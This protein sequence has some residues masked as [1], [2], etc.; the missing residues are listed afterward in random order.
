MATFFVGRLAALADQ[1][2]GAS[3]RRRKIAGRSEPAAYAT[4]GV[5]TSDRPSSPLDVDGVIS[6]FG[7]EGPSS[8]VPGRFHLI[9]GMAHC[10]PDGIGG[11]L[12]RLGRGLRAGLGDRLGGPRQRPPAG[13]PRAARRAPVPDL[14]RQR[15][16]RHGP[17]E[18]RRPSTATPGSA[19][20]LGGRLH[21]RDLPGLGGRARRPHPPGPDR[22]DIGPHRRAR[23]GPARAGSRRGVHCLTRGGVLADLLPGGDP[24][25]PRRRPALPRLVGDQADARDRGG[26]PGAEIEFRATGDPRPPTGAVEPHAGRATRSP[27]RPPHAPDAT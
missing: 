18:D 25:D 26:S 12:A 27:R 4:L 10:I 6:L 1:L 20:G 3:A 22:A 13:D 19:A 17:L 14:R 9:D 21:R 15:P 23:R 7:F 5:V 8:E 16:L 2:T 11:R 24:E